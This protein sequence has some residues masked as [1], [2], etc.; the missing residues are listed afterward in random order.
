M[1]FTDPGTYKYDCSVHGGAMTGTIVVLPSASPTS[2][3][4]YDVTATTA[5][6]TGDTFGAS[7]KWD[8]TALTVAR[9]ADAV[10]VMLDFSQDVV[11][12]TTGDPSA[13]LAFVDLDVDQDFST[14]SPAIA[15][16]F[17]QD[18]KSTVLGVDARINLAAPD[19]NGRIAVTDGLGREVGRV[20]PAYAGKRVTVRVPTTMLGD[21]DGYV[22]AAAIV[23]ISGAPSDIVPQVGHLALTPSN[24]KA[25]RIERPVAI[26]FLTPE[27]DR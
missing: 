9:D 15:D 20:T 1:T 26:A 25:D 17:R 14:G 18:G 16:E 2:G 10:A 3:G 12:P 8:V 4:D 11:P 19:E 6:P 27:L 13:V 23:G 22:S 21:D 24:Q 7:A 5:D